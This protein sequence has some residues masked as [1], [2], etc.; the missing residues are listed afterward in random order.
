VF[1]NLKIDEDG[2]ALLLGF[3]SH[4]AKQSFCI[5]PVGFQSVFISATRIGMTAVNKDKFH[6]NISSYSYYDDNSWRNK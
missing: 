5:D 4:S 6:Y 2:V 1:G 3:V